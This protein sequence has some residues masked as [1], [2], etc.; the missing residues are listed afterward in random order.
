MR[1]WK[2]LFVN[3]CRCR[4][5]ISVATKFVSSWQDDMIALM[6]L[7]IMLKIM[8]VQC[9]KLTTINAAVIPRLIFVT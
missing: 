6:C 8:L 2:C 5:P 9:K 1:K 3:C 4:S 7:D